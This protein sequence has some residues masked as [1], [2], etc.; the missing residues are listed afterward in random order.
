MKRHVHDAMSIVGEVLIDI[1]S[2]SSSVP[3]SYRAHQLLAGKWRQIL[4]DK[5]TTIRLQN[6]KISI[7]NDRDRFRNELND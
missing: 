2:L 6:K 5:I 3:L 4:Y 1:P 7:F